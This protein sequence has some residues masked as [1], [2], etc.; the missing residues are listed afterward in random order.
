MNT[1]FTVVLIVLAFVTGLFLG[2]ALMTGGK[3]GSK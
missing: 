2:V 1:I 3:D